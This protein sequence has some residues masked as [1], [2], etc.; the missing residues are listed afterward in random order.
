[1]IQIRKATTQD[2]KSIVALFDEY[3]VFYEKKS[4]KQ[5]AEKFIAERLTL[6]DSQIFVAEINEVHEEINKKRNQ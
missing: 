2:L 5:T 3:R 4:D 1:M 6:H